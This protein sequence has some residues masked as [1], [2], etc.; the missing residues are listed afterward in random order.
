MKAW[1]ENQRI[2]D[3]CAGDP[4]ALFHPDVAALYDTEVPDDACS[5][6]GWVNGELVKPE[7]VASAPLPPATPPKVSPVQFMLL[8]TS[9]ERVAIKAARATDPVIDDWLDII[10]DPRL[11]EVDLGLA[12]TDQA[13]DYLVSSNLLTEQRKSAILTG[14]PQ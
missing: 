5:G 2:R 6:D 13:L 9:A 1:I 7:P 8:L 14:N 4:F 11:T 10:E 12:S 3:L